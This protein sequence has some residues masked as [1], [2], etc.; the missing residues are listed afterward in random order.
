MELKSISRIG[1]LLVLFVTTLQVAAVATGP[2][3]QNEPPTDLAKRDSGL[4]SPGQNPAIIGQFK[5]GPDGY[6]YNGPSSISS[7][8]K[9]ANTSAAQQTAN[10]ESNVAS[11]SSTSFGLLVGTLF[12]SSV[13]GSACL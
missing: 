4:Y 13:L 12:V 1:V 8:S 11:V 3:R 9:P 2:A 10:D 5:G 6:R 7:A